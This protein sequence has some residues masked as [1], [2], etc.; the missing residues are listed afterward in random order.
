MVLLQALKPPSSQIT[1]KL[2]EFDLNMENVDAQ[3]WISTIDMCIMDKSTNS[4]PWLI[5]LTKAS[6]G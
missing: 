4:A 6:K 3:A 1:V 2:P 5:S